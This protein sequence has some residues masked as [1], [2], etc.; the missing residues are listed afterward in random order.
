[1]KHLF[2]LAFSII[3]ITAF[4]G[5][6][7]LPTTEEIFEKYDKDQNF[8]ITYSEHKKIYQ[9]FKAEINGCLK[10][11][12]EFL[13]KKVYFYFMKYGE[14][15]AGTDIEGNVRLLFLRKKRVRT[16]YGIMNEAL[17]LLEEC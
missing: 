14:F 10:I 13:L 6:T 1:M 2:T 16:R 11:K 4:A 7:E 9:D 5:N 17:L 3:S 15:P 12:K 8:L